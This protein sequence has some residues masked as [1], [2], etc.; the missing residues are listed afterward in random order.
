MPTVYVDKQITTE[1]L[2][3]LPKSK[4]YFPVS[5]FPFLHT[6]WCSMRRFVAIAVG[7]LILAGCSSKRTTVSGKITYEGQPVNGVILHFY[8]NS[9]KAKETADVPIAVSQE[10]TFNATGIKPGDYKIVVEARKVDDMAMKMKNMK[11][12]KADEARQK[13]EQSQ[14]QEKPTIDFPKK[15]QNVLSTDLTCNITGGP[16]E[17]NLVLKK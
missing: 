16:Q 1:V 7:F 13:L 11:G 6:F 9:D 4:R 17:L 2:P 3:K 15:Y 5:P 8:P 12:A 10:G 14:G